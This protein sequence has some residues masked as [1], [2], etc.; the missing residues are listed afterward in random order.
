M[1]MRFSKKV[2]EQLNFT[3]LGSS[4]FFFTTMLPLKLLAMPTRSLH[5]TG[6]VI[7]ESD[8]DADDPLAAWREIPRR[9]AV[10]DDAESFYETS[11][12][13][14]SLVAPAEALP[15]EGSSEPVAAE[16]LLPIPQAPVHM[17]PPVP[18]P[19]V[20]IHQARPRHIYGASCGSSDTTATP[21]PAYTA[22]APF[23]GVP[24]L[25]STITEQFILAQLGIMHLVGPYEPV[26]I[27][28]PHLGSTRRSTG[29]LTLARP[30]AVIGPISRSRY[31]RKLPQQDQSMLSCGSRSSQNPRRDHDR[32]GGGGTAG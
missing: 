8:D 17:T 29:T 24:P 18:P 1:R 14:C 16:T 21:V 30:T 19:L 31:V 25:I 26:S 4:L 22:Y 11:P 13:E 15:P 23:P 32:R 27:I 5:S 28:P 10:E 2:F 7:I 6:S 3:L 12:A 20:P 9:D